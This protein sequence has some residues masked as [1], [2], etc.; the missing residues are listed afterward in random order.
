MKKITWLILIIYSIGCSHPQLTPDQREQLL[1]GNIALISINTMPEFDID[2]PANG[3]LESSFKKGLTWGVA[4]L[5]GGL[6]G[7]GTGGC[8][9]DFCG[10][11]LVLMLG[12]AATMGVVGGLTGSIV[13]AVQANPS[14]AAEI[15]SKE[16]MLKLA[17][18]QLQDGLRAN[19]VFNA[20]AKNNTRLSEIQVPNCSSLDNVNDQALVTNE[21]RTTMSATINYIGLKGSWDNDPS[22]KL[23]I[24][25]QVALRKLGTGKNYY[26]NE[27]VYEGDEKK[28]SEWIG[29]NGD[30]LRDEIN[31]GVL[32]VADKIT[33]TLFDLPL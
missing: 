30:V 18:M 23:I 28:F 14:E 8:G 5:A 24:K 31:N 21:V 12:L 19:L 11:A 17:G 20:K 10:A 25:A 32:D 6:S 1:I 3:R 33:N 29:Q 16:L 2:K 9:G 15:K 7:L 4:S 22:L 26:N 27:F 13:G